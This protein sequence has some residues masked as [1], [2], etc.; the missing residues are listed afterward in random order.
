M[1]TQTRSSSS[2]S[3]R[4]NVGRPERYQNGESPKQSRRGHGR[5]QRGRG[6]RQ[7]GCGRRQRG[8]GGIAIISIRTITPCQNNAASTT[9]TTTTTASIQN[10][11]TRPVPNMEESIQP[12]NDW[13]QLPENDEVDPVEVLEDIPVVLDGATMYRHTSHKH[14]NSRLWKCVDCGWYGHKSRRAYTKCSLGNEEKYKLGA[15]RPF[16]TIAPDNLQPPNENAMEQGP[17][18]PDFKGEWLPYNTEPNFAPRKATC[19]AKI[20]VN[21]NKTTYVNENGTEKFMEWDTLPV[22]MYNAFI[23]K[24]DNVDADV[25]MMEWTHKKYLSENRN[26]NLK[27][28]ITTFNQLQGIYLLNGVRP[29]PSFRDH[30]SRD[31]LMANQDVVRQLGDYHKFEVLKKYLRMQDPEVA[32]PLVGEFKGDVLHVTRP[33]LEALRIACEDAFILGEHFS[34]DE[35]VIGFQGSFMA[36]KTRITYKR[37]GDG[38]LLDAI[39]DSETGA[40]ITFKFRTDDPEGIPSRP[41]CSNLINRCMFMI[42]KPFIAGQWRHCVCDNLYSSIKFNWYAWKEAKVL[43]T[44]VVRDGRGFSLEALTE[45]KLLGIKS[46]EQLKRAKEEQTHS[47]RSIVFDHGNEKFVLR[48]T[49]VYDNSKDPVKFYSTHETTLTPEGRARVQNLK[50]KV[51]KK[52]ALPTANGPTAPPKFHYVPEEI[53]F[54]RLM[55]IHK[56]N[57]LMGGVDLQDRF[58]WYYRANGKHVWRARKWTLAFLTWVIDTRATQAYLMHKILATEAQEKWDNAF[59][60]AMDKERNADRVG[61]TRG[62]RHHRTDAEIKTFLESGSKF[63]KNGKQRPEIMLHKSFQ[64]SI[65][66]SK[67]NLPQIEPIWMIKKRGQPRKNT[68]KTLGKIQHA[69]A[70]AAAYNGPSKNNKRKLQF[71]SW[72]NS[73]NSAG[74][75]LSARLYQPYHLPIPIKNVNLGDRGSSTHRCQVCRVL[76]TNKN[77]KYER[78]NGVTLPMAQFTCNAGGCTCPSSYCT[79]ECFYLYHQGV[80]TPSALKEQRNTVETYQYLDPIKL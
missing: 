9:T 48:A 27:P 39:C 8:R 3:K 23:G 28:D 66:R 26:L 60:E 50:R 24:I 59:K 18:D 11:R 69:E 75:G 12:L 57:K 76:G 71:P 58:R 21:R 74:N 13:P 53:S 42:N 61:F 64:L 62:Q 25:K 6:R 16:G 54:I 73:K 4:K 32:I 79:L 52:Q 34:L 47:G 55:V 1:P 14:A 72:S 17:L 22:Y 44:Q 43:M 67:L 35:I 63:G 46:K 70:F 15:T 20:K 31:P 49:S 10:G 36:G 78:N 30:F 37:E 40:L 65:A 2:R 80:E 19:G 38:M 41:D 45:L 33:M 77:G 29:T 7:R 68:V 56:Y 51:F 5:R